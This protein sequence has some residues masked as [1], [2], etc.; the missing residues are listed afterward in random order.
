[1][2]AVSHFYRQLALTPRSPPEHLRA[3][4]TTREKEF[5]LC[6]VI[7]TAKTS[8][9]LFNNNHNRVKNNTRVATHAKSLLHLLQRISVLKWS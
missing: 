6:G 5:P 8:R 1:M 9:N 4:A 2:F 3:P 7:S